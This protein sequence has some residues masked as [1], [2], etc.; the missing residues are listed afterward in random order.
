MSRAPLLRSPWAWAALLLAAFV[1]LPDAAYGQRRKK[2]RC[3]VCR[4]DPEL[5][6]KNG[7]NHGPFAFGRTDSESIEKDLYWPAVWIETE[8]FRIGGDPPS[9]KVPEAERKAYR[10]E[11]E[12]LAEKWPRVKPKTVILDTWLRIHLLAERM[13]AFYD[14]FL[15]LVGTSDEEFADPERNRMR[16]LGPYLG[17]KEKYEIMIFEQRSP[18]RDYMSV[19]WGLT[20]VK[21]QRWNNVERDCLWF[22]LNLEEEQIRHDQHLHNVCRH[23]LAHNL[24][25]GYLHYSYDLPVWITEGFAHW[26]ERRNDPRFNMFDSIEGSFTEL[27]GLERWAP[28]VRK[29]V[30]KDEAA[31][32]ASLLR[33]AS[34][35]EIG[36]EDHL[37]CW[38]KIDFLIQSN[39]DAFAKWITALKSRRNAQGYPDGSGLDD[40]QREGFKEFFGWNVQQAERRWQAWVLDNYPAK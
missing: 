35:A 26:C 27:K 14:E 13:E 19:T 15:E 16:G 21:P 40:A 34:F 6:E 37:V 38:S 25:D 12:K 30:V 17:E 9:W 36:W 10:A 32:I 5:M 29:L 18:Y 24:L 22:G 31:T 23:N 3:T 8:H 1:L 4:H 7:I 39:P 20:Y 2:D 11:L 33:R 28:E